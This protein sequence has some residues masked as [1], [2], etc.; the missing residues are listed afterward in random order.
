[1]FNL[2]LL[3]YFDI[4]RVEIENGRYYKS[5]DRF[6]IKNLNVAYPSVTTVLSNYYGEKWIDEWKLRI[7]EEE[8]KKASNKAKNRG[9][10]MHKIYE[11]FLLNKDY[12]K[13]A[14]PINLSD[15]EKVKPKLIENITKVYGA[16]IPLISE[17]FKTGGTTD[18]L[19][20]WQGVP[21]VL[22][23]KTSKKAK[24]INDISSYLTQA[25]VYSMMIE[26][27]YNIKVPQFAII[28][29]VDNEEP[30]I[31]LE[32]IEKYVPIVFKIFVERTKCQPKYLTA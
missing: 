13:K 28:M 20:E 30:I 7:G 5:A 22:D 21:T 26:E 10:A 29:T 8:A 16:E 25:T 32:K 1:M 27:M 31:F 23:F 18:A 4:Q 3:S 6:L 24:N 14:M 19:V 11:D 12:R 17:R 2:S 9:T 15:F